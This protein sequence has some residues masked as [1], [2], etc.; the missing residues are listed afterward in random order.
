MS[1]EKNKTTL[2]HLSIGNKCFRTHWE[3]QIKKI[4]EEKL[5]STSTPHFTAVLKLG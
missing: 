2:Y 1:I 5:H 4:D 3:D